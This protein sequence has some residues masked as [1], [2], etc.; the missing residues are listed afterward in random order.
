MLVQ[1]FYNHSLPTL[2]SELTP[3][4]DLSSISTTMEIERCEKLTVVMIGLNGVEQTFE[5]QQLQFT[6]SFVLSFD[7]DGG[8]CNLWLLAT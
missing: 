5:C 1:V 4:H 7:R 8:Q 3:A 2:D 6:R